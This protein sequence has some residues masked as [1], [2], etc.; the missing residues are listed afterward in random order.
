MSPALIALNVGIILV[1]LVLFAYRTTVVTLFLLLCPDSIWKRKTAGG[2]WIHYQTSLP[3]A[4]IWEQR[5]SA[6]DAASRPPC[7]AYALGAEDR[8]PIKYRV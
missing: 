4:P 8:G 6:K 2:Y 3:M 5:E 7:L 1:L